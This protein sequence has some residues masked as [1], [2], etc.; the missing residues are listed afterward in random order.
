VLC[1]GAGVLDRACGAEDRALGCD[2]DGALGVDRALGPLDRFTGARCGVLRVLPEAAG[3]VRWS[4][5]LGRLGVARSGAAEEE[6]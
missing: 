4:V 3:P 2:L 6:D 1:L 5:A